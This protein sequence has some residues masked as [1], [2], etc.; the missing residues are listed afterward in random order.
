MLDHILTHGKPMRIEEI[1]ID[2]DD[3]AKIKIDCINGL[4]ECDNRIYDTNDVT[5]LLY[6]KSTNM[7]VHFVLGKE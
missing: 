7:T 3:V 6:K 5:K 1:Y 4:I 2:G